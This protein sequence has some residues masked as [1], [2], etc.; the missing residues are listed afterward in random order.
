MAGDGQFDCMAE[1][2]KISGAECV[3]IFLVLK[4]QNREFYDIK[5]ASK[6]KKVVNSYIEAH[7]TALV[8]IQFAEHVRNQNVRA[9]QGQ[10]QS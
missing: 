2:I 6:T 5:K 8:F 9:R 3:S 4:K 10:K 1:I 7:H